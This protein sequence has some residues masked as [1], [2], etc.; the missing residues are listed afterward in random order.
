MTSYEEAEKMWVPDPAWTIGGNGKTCRYG[1]GLHLYCRAPAVASLKRGRT[2]RK[3]Y[4]CADH[5]F[6]RRINGGVVEWEVVKQ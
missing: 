2:G 6:G 4:Y 5:L 3:W 1:M